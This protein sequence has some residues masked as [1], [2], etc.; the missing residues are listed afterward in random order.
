MNRDILRTPTRKISPRK[1]TEW[2]EESVDLLAAN[3]P[4]T[5]PL[6]TLFLNAQPAAQTPSRLIPTPLSTVTES[7][8][9]PPAKFVDF[10]FKKPLAPTPRNLI[11]K[12]ASRELPDVEDQ[13]PK[14]LIKSI[15]TSSTPLSVEHVRRLELEEEHQDQSD[16]Q[17][18]PEVDEAES[19][20]DETSQEVVTKLA[21]KVTDLQLEVRDLGIVKD[22][23]TRI[24][25]IQSQE[26]VQVEQLSR[27]MQQSDVQLATVNTEVRRLK[28]QIDAFGAS[29]RAQKRDSDQFLPVTSVAT[30]LTLAA[31]LLFSLWT[32]GLLLF[33]LG[34]ES[35]LTPRPT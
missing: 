14:K 13:T 9:V 16:T 32:V 17:N 33:P 30:F 2:N 35:L 22:S 34:D 20:E 6:R 21:K 15:T 28:D 25:E 8:A 3:E 24:T 7:P 1:D 10:E 4:S 12:V 11:K 27:T 5:T 29:L 23:W 26:K 19:N 18:Q 31:I